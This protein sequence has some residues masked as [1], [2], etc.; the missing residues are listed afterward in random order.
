MGELT[1]FEVT[2]R[3]D[4]LYTCRV[5]DFSRSR[6]ATTEVRVGFKP[7]FITDEEENIDFVHEALVLLV[8][9]AEG[10]PMP[11]VIFI[12]TTISYTYIL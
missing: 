4:G 2:R 10:E 3:N 12:N 8:C 1:L 9:E 5:S 7:K 6:S 11:K